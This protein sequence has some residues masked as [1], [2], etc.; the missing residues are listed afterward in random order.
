M[1]GVTG[2][3]N[4]TQQTQ[5]TNS[6]EGESHSKPPPIPYYVEERRPISKLAATSLIISLVGFPCLREMFRTHPFWTG[7]PLEKARQAVE[8]V[9]FYIIPLAAIIVGIAALL[10]MAD[11][12]GRLRGK[13]LAWTG[14]LLS[15]FWLVTILIVLVTLRFP[16]PN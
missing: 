5:Q 15:L 12:D 1:S 8:A 4:L 11:A 6:P 16:T 3:V 10:H 14:I 9:P 13:W 2:G 7:H